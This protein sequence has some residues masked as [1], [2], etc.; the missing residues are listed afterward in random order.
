MGR[1]NEAQAERKLAQ[2]LEPLNPTINLAQG[3]AFT[4]TVI[5]IRRSHNFKRPWS[6]ILTS[7]RRK[8]SLRLLMSRSG[9]TIKA[10]AG[11]ENAIA[12]QSGGEL[13]ESIAGLGHVYAVLGRKDEAL[14]KIEELNNSRPED[15]YRQTA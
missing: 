7:H 14:G 10:I 13:S 4:G 8:I 5:S 6:W 9:C 15:I 1:S 11:F 2:E 12:Q 3:V